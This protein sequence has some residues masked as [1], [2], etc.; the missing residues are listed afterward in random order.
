MHKPTVRPG[1][2]IISVTGAVDPVALTGLA[3]DA[4]VVSNG[5]RFGIPFPPIA[6]HTLRS[7]RP[8]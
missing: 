6:E 7:H 8:A 2:W 4:K 5:F 1:G 3:L